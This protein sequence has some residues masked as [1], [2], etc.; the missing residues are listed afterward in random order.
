VSPLPEPT[1]PDK[2]SQDSAPLE[3]RPRPR[4]PDR[5]TEAEA[6]LELGC[7][8]AVL[9]ETGGDPAEVQR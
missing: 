4:P 7:D 9:E 6:V 1:D 5:L 2:P 3:D 8:V